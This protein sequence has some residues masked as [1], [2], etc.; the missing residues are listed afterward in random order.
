MARHPGIPL[1]AVTAT[2]RIE[3]GV[4]RVRLGAS[5]LQMIEQAGMM[6]CVLA[7]L[8]GDAGQVVAG[9]ERLLDAVDGLVLTGGE[10]VEPAQYRAVP[11]PRLGRT[12]AAR[13]ATEISA[14]R[15]ARERG[16][17]TLAICRGVQVLNVALG[18][19]LIQD[20]PSERPGPINHDPDEARDTRTHPLRLLTGCRTA[21]ALG[22]TELDVNSVHHQ[23]IDR[24]APGLRITAT[25]PDGVI[26][27]VE[28]PLD[29]VWWVLGVQWH[30][31]EFVGDP[32]AVDRGLFRALAAAARKYQARV[33]D[34]GRG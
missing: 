3:E 13:D 5:Y 31:E 12:Q 9:V 33:S 19:T 1:I 4:D 23:A 14:V 7:P 32:A 17:P 6:P 29:D 11:S 16:L 2:R 30:P 28:T 26:E 25:A 24:P 21:C 27:G 20:L 10:D 22:A 15:A 8:D 18:G 34:P